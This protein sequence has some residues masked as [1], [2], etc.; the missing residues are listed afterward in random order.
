M[1]KTFVRCPLRQWLQL[2]T[3]TYMTNTLGLFQCEKREEPKHP[4]STKQHGVTHQPN[5]KISGE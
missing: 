3:T 5:P 2:S 1:N 4:D